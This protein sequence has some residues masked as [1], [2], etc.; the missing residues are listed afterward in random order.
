MRL[1]HKDGKYNPADVL[2]KHMSSPE[3]FSLI[4]TLFFWTWHDD[5]DLK[6]SKDE[7]RVIRS[8]LKRNRS[9]S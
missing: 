6:I 8:I 4:K 9:A 7:G 1:C 3:L 5:H 2:N